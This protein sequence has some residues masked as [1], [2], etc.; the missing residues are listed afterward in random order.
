MSEELEIDPVE[1]DEEDLRTG[2]A[3][4]NSVVW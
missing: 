2:E 3:G 1:S 4:R